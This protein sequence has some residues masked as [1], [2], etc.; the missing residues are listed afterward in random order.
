MSPL[1]KRISAF[2]HD[3]Q[4][5][6]PEDRI[7][8]AIS[9][10]P[11]SVFLAYAM[12]QLGYDTGLIH[13]NYQ[14]RGA[15]SNREEALVRQYAKAWEVPLFVKKPA[16]KK[17][18]E[19][20]KGSLQEVARKIRYDF[21]EKIMDKE[22]Y[23]LCALAH[24]ADDQSEQAMLSLL[25][26]NASSLLQKI[27]VKRDRYIRPLLAV[28]R[29][30]IIEALTEAGLT[31]ALD[32]SNQK[33]DYLRNRVRNRVF[34]VLREVN[35][36]ADE[37]LRRKQEQ[38]AAQKSF[39][40]SVLASWAASCL[41][42]TATESVQQIDWR[43]F[44]DS[45]GKQHLPLFVAY[46]LEQWGLHGHLLWQGV[47]LIDTQVGKKVLVGE[48]QLLRIRNGLQWGRVE[49]HFQK[50]IEIHEKDILAGC[51]KSWFRRK[52]HFKLLG[53]AKPQLG[54]RAHF[55]LD[56]D[57]IRFPLCLRAWEEGDTM[58]AFGMQGHKKLS[59]IFVDEK[60]TSVQKQEAFVLED[61]ERVLLLSDFRIAEPVRLTEKTKSILLVEVL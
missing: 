61:K 19:A 32:S 6:Q 23:D 57:R 9:G 21:F 33:N 44:V 7:L 14:F 30:E 59:D 38:Y 47:S 13:I 12:R 26:G 22:G 28:S 10:G 36:K 39:L 41:L 55:Y 49:A 20:S 60:F 56:M 35:P 29:V 8:L 43:P 3:Q 25:T 37:H 48:H 58:Q 50:A 2:I 53:D 5:C 54:N 16:A 17:Q 42:S 18:V 27:P 40:D 31:Y 11:D 45:W 51:V 34:P 46:V 15:E 24:Q 4:L 1:L 52:L